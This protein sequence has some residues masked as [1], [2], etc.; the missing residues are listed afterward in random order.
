MVALAIPLSKAMS[1]LCG[2]MTPFD[3][4]LGDISAWLKLRAI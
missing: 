4:G 1:T 3:K 2:A